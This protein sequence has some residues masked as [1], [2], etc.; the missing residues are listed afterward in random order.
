M[1]DIVI[2]LPFDYDSYLEGQKIKWQIDFKKNYSNYIFFYGTTSIILFLFLIIL[3]LGDIKSYPPSF[4][5]IALFLI[6]YNILIPWISMYK[7]KLK[8]FKAA[9]LL[10]IAQKKTGSVTVLSLNEQSLSIEDAQRS[11]KMQ[12]TLFLP[13]YIFNDAIILT[14]TN[15]VGNTIIIQKGQIDEATYIQLIELL[16]KTIGSR[17]GI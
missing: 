6:F 1:Q 16:T 13:F 2:N 4:F 12:W 5:G 11:I 9:E 14:S 7:N 10:A 3:V 15:I 8:F 17:K